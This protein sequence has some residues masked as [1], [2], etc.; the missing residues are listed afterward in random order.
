MFSPLTD[1]FFL[2]LTKCIIFCKLDSFAHTTESVASVQQM[3]LFLNSQWINKNVKNAHRFIA[4][5]CVYAMFIASLLLPWICVALRDRKRRFC[6]CFVFAVFRVCESDAMRGVVWFTVYYI[7]V[8]HF[9][10]SWTIWLFERFRALLCCGFLLQDTEMWLHAPSG[11]RWPPFF[12][13]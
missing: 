11:V 4:F 12:M 2:Y 10:C 13:P 9:H 8:L 6:W 5:V 7:Y 3:Y 1:W